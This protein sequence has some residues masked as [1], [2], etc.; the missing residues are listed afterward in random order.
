MLRCK[1][2]LQAVHSYLR[3]QWLQPA[4][5]KLQLF[6]C[7]CQINADACQSGMHVHITEFLQVAQHT[8]AYG[9]LAA[10]LS[11]TAQV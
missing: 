3:K 8:R 1:A 10:Q 11:V 4:L 2:K 9:G 6:R 5:R 7:V